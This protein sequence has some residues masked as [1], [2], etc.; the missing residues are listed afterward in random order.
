VAENR[1]VIRKDNTQGGDEQYENVA[2]RDI[3]HGI[4]AS[5]LDDIRE[6]QMRLVDAMERQGD[7]FREELRETRRELSSRVDRAKDEIK[8]HEI[9][10][11]QRRKAD[12]TDRTERQRVIDAQL[13]AILA[14]QERLRLAMEARSARTRRVLFWL[15][16]G[17]LVAL[18]IGGW[19][20]YDRYSAL[21]MVR[22]W[23]GGSA[24]LAW[25]FLRGR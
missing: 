7:K 13:E 24:A 18:L 22:V 23:T 19:L 20:A 15:G 4:P 21:A 9:A 25:A 3:I 12:D 10:E 11:T 6:V 14:E 16:V 17:L 8:L 5:V 2:G 1:P